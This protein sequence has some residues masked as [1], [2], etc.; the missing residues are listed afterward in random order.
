[1]PLRDPFAFA[2]I[3]IYVLFALVAFIA[4]QLAPNRSD[5]DPVHQGGQGRSQHAAKR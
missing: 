4:D 2:G 5:G 1:M 3:L